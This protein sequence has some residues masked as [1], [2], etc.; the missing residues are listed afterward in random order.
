MA[1]RRTSTLLPVDFFTRG[2]RISGHISTRAK[3]VGDI[4][5][6]TLSS[7]V[8][9]SD[10]YISRVTNPAEI[11]ATYGYSQLLKDN[12]LFAIVSVEESYSKAGRAVSYF[13]KQR[14]PAWVVLPTFEIE[15]EFLVTGRSADFASYLAKGVDAYIPIQKGVAR[16]ASKP[17]ITFNGEAFLVNRKNIDLF[18]LNDVS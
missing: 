8:Q 6:D 12:L 10:V 13:G 15:G 9:L 1:Q 17:E 7:Y 16:V 18:C 4:L 14:R 5:N 3:T 11:V 2:Y